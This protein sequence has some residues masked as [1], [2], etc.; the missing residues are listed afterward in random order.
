MSN[1]PF[2]IVILGT[3]NL[4]NQLPTD[5]DAQASE[6]GRQLEALGHNVHSVQVVEGHHPYV[7]PPADDPPAEGGGDGG[8]VGQ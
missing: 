7:A 4:H 6:A 2:T 3:G 5:A 1:G 8:N